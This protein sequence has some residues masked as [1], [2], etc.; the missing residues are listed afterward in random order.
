MLDFHK[1]FSTRTNADN[2]KKT[3]ITWKIMRITRIITRI[4]VESQNFL[5]DVVWC[6][7]PP[8]GRGTAR[9]EISKRGRGVAQTRTICPPLLVTPESCNTFLDYPCR[10]HWY[11]V[12]VC[13]C[14]VRRRLQLLQICGTVGLSLESVVS[15]RVRSIMRVGDVSG[16]SKACATELVRRTSHIWTSSV[17][18]P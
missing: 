4:I 13:V 14:C 7:Q 9:T 1:F 5:A 2:T 3:R 12:L 8:R 15:S 16:G 10:E 11:P 17:L 6:G 18:Q